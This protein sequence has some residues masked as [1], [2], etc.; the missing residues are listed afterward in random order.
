MVGS[1]GGEVD[2][3]DQLLFQKYKNSIQEKEIERQK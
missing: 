2:E 3:W 1:N